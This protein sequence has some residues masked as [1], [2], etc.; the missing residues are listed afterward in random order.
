MRGRAVVAMLVVL[1]ALLLVPSS[2]LACPVCFG[3]I[4][5]PAAEGVNNGVMTMLAVVGMVQFGLVTMFVGMWRRNR[6]LQEGEEIPKVSN[7]GVR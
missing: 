3:Q 6:R 1:T 5:G 4:E 7:G 2:A